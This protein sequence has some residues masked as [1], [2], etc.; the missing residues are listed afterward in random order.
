MS[1]TSIEHL[2]EREAVIQVLSRYARG[3]D[4]REAELY[5]S[6]LADPIDV[7]AGQYGG[8][9]MRADAWVAQAFEIAN[10]YTTT[11]HIITNHEVEFPDGPDGNEARCLAYLQAQH[12]REDES[13]LLG[14]RY[15]HRLRR[16]DGQWRIY[17]ITLSVDWIQQSGG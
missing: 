12:W 15:D 13:Q 2:L 8:K 11:Q 4:R 3:I 1:E 10:G 7:E 16:E 5:R 14:G 6:C 17:Q 9:G